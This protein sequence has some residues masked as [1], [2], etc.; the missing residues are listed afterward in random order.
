VKASDGL[1]GRR[2]R[3]AMISAAASSV[4][5]ARDL[6]NLQADQV[7]KALKQALE[8]EKAQEKYG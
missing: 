2:L 3:K 5:T 8:I 4:E 6:N 7:L 1:D